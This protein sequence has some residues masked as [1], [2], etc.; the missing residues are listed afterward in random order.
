MQRIKVN[1]RVV[2]FDDE[3]IC[4]RDAS[5]DNLESDIAHTLSSGGYITTPSVLDEQRSFE[6]HGSIAKVDNSMTTGVWIMKR[7]SPSL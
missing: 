3:M 7:I 2:L 4:C 1:A 5:S 6:T